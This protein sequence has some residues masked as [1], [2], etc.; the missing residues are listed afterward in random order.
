MLLRRLGMTRPSM[1]GLDLDSTAVGGTVMCA[2]CE[3]LVVT[4]TTWLDQGA[5]Q[6]YGKII[7][8]QTG[9]GNNWLH[10]FIGKF[11]CTVLLYRLII[12]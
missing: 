5:R 6:H 1:Y 3:K 2:S 9:M 8:P 12:I 4:W 7:L 10:C 11:S